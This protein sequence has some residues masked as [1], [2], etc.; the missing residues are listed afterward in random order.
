MLFT[1]LGKQKSM[2]PRLRDS[3]PLAGEDC[4]VEDCSVGAE[5]G[6]PARAAALVQ[7]DVVPLAAQVGVRV[8]T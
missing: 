5:E 8:V 6:D 2:F 1:V 7:A 3:P 4:L